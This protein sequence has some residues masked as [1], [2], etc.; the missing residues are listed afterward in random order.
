MSYENAPAT[1]M[2]ATQCAACARPLVDATSVETGMGP[3][4]RKKYGVDDLDPEARQQANKLVY[5]IAQDQDGATVLD[6]TARLRELGFGALAARI[7]KRLKIIT[8]F[9]C[10]AGLVVKTPFDPNVV[11]AMREIP[12]RRWDKE[13]KTNI[14]P[15]TADRQ[16]WGLLQ[17]FYP[18][19]TALGIHG[20]FTI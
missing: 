6:C 2:L 8:V 12:G 19:Q 5:Q 17:R 7:I 18:G 9:R 11:E 10:D 14:F 15:A 13:R 16:V 20:A 4:C 3:D 1:R